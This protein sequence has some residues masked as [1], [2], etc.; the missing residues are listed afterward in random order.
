MNLNPVL[1]QVI[2]ETAAPEERTLDLNTLTVESG[3]TLTKISWNNREDYEYAWLSLDTN[4]DMKKTETGYEVTVLTSMYERIWENMEITG[5]QND[6]L[7]IFVE[8]PEPYGET[9]AC[10]L[11]AQH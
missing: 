7:V 8:R 1:E 3:E 4:Y 6:G 9:L 5:M 11:L 2:E 10:F